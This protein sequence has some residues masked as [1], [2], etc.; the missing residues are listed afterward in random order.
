MSKPIIAYVRVSTQKQGQSS[1]GLEGQEAA[2]ERFCA[3]EGSTRVAKTFAEIER[4]KG[5]TR[6]SGGRS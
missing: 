2:I 1:L 5:Q 3:A 6:S 4:G